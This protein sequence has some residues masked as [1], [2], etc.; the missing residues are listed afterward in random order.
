MNFRN[1]TIEQQTIRLRSGETTGLGPGLVL[2]HCRIESHISARELVL[3][4]VEMYHCAF[5][6]KKTITGYKFLRARFYDSTFEGTYSGCDFGKRTEVYDNLGDIV[7][8]DFSK[9]RLDGC[10]FFNCDIDALNLATSRP[11]MVI[12]SPKQRATAADIGHL[13]P[14]LKIF[15]EVLTEES[16]DCTA[17]VDD[18]ELRAKRADCTALDVMALARA[19]HA[20]VAGESPPS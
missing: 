2:R 19:L 17:I 7:R 9:A 16:T 5:V 1:Q 13:V 4:D 6:T 8:C 14:R 11:A 15:A 10:R 3:T 18:I 20:T 12:R